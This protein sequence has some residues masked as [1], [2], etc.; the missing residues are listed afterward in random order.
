MYDFTK[1]RRDR[2]IQAIRHTITPSIGFSYAPD[3][4]DP[5]YGYQSNYQSD[6]TGTFR[7]I[8][9]IRSMPTASPVR[10]VRCR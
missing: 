9:P 10:D 3:F 2:K 1:K 5:K 4:G 7:P 6:S 8:R